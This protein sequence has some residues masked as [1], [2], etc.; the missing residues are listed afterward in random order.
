MNRTACWIL[1]LSMGWKMPTINSRLISNKTWTSQD[2]VTT[3]PSI[4]APIRSRKDL[5]I[6]GG[7]IQTASN[8][9]TWL[10]INL[11][12]LRRLSLKHNKVQNPA[13]VSLILMGTLISMRIIFTTIGGGL[14][15]TSIPS[16]SIRLLEIKLQSSWLR[17]PNLNTFWQ[18]NMKAW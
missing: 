8:L 6:S 10:K 4:V 14:F 15:S 16:P 5:Q 9:T 7:K 2:S 13:W 3:V 12:R 18:K 17:A 1:I 11:R